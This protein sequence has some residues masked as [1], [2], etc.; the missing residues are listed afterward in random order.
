MKIRTKMISVVLG[1]TI[2]AL[3]IVLF[4]GYKLGKNIVLTNTRDNIL[5]NTRE[6]AAITKVFFNEKFS[7]ANTIGS[8]P[9]LIKTL[10]S[11]NLELSALSE[12]QRDE[13][14]DTLNKK[15]I[16]ASDLKSPFIQ[17]YMN[18]SLANYLRKQQ[19]VI[20]GEYGE[21]FLTNR[22]GVLIATTGKLTTLAHSHKYW[23]RACYNNGSGKG[24]I[25]DRGYDESVGDNVVGIVVPIMSDGH[26]IGVLK[27]N[28]FTKSLSEF[29]NYDHRNKHNNESNLASFLLRSNGE[30]IFKSNDILDTTSEILIRKKINGKAGKPEFIFEEEEYMAAYVPIDVPFA[31]DDRDSSQQVLLIDHKQGNTGQDWWFATHTTTTN[32]LAPLRKEIKIAIALSLLLIITMTGSVLAMCLKITKPIKL[33]MRYSEKIGRGDLGAKV[34]LESNDELGQLATSFNKMAKDLNA[35]TTSINKLNHEISVH[36]QTRENLD[37]LTA[38]LENTSDLVATAALD[39]QL[40]YFNSAGRRLIGWGG[41]DSLEDK[42]ISNVHPKW[43]TEIIEKEGIP[44]A[45]RDGIW[46]GETAVLDPD[47]KDIH[48][49]QVIMSHKS[50][51]GQVDYLSTII[52]DITQRK[53]AENAL[54]DSKRSLAMAQQVAKIGSWDWNI[55]NDKLAWSDETYRQMGLEPNEIEPTYEAFQKFVHPDDLE[56][57]N[58][59]VGV[60]LEEHKLYSTEA[61][62]I[63]KDGTEW[64]MHA[65]GM[66][67]RN[68]DGKVVRLIGTQQDITERKRV[69]DAL[70]NT[71]EEV[72]Y[73]NKQLEASIERANQ[74][75]QEATVANQTKSEFLA[76]MSHEIRTPM[77]SILGFSEMLAQEQLSDEQQDYVNTIWD[78]GKNLLTIIND[79]LDFSKIEAGKLDTEIIECS[80]EK[81]LGNINSMLRPQATEKGLDFKVLHKTELPAQ[82]R[83]DYTRVYQCL[84]NLVGNAIKFTENGHVHIIVS[85]E[86]IEDKP[87][88]RFDI[89]DTGIG[90]PVDKQEAIF[91]SF[92]QADGSTTR[93]FGGT[94]LGLTI[95]KS[96]AEIL[97]GSITVQSEP[98]KG[99]IFS[100][101]IPAGLDVASQ[102]LLGE[103]YMKEYT[104]ESSET[105]EENYVGNILVAEDNPS[106]QKLIEILLKR[107]GLKVTLVDDGQQAVDEVMTQ[108]FDLVFMDMQMPVM[109]GY[110]VTELLR[111]KEMTVPIV[112]LT[113]NAM[114]QD[115]QECLDAGCD[116]YLAKPV[117]RKKLSKMLGKYL[118]SDSFENIQQVEIQLPPAIEQPDDSPIVSELADDPDLREV[119]EVFVQDLPCQLQK[120]GEAVDSADLD[121]LKYL[122]HTIKGAG[123]SSG[124]PVIMAKAAETEQFILTGELDSLKTA[125]DELTQLC[126]RATADEK[127]S[128]ST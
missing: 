125:I 47:G 35:S 1:T 52:R 117:D 54:L 44:G 94:G 24:I 8:N 120:I 12:K 81:L 111:K 105:A 75:A 18:N 50:S 63:R 79:I 113:A 93:K 103:A 127:A 83:T 15:W 100:L 119:A 3:V 78:S 21:I 74:M 88:I 6:H 114:K 13:Y 92:S 124:F 62:M 9:D 128:T 110:E 85:T 82:I 51:N 26:L 65:Q 10:I 58:E 7:I 31:I 34:K 5:I 56:Q 40:T 68:D 39:Q 84:T 80:L 108:S 11:S 69:E 98:S 107:M 64:V 42:K 41:D 101:M 33:L 77:N 87:F 14:I 53:Q 122:I 43:A 17:S 38:I 104:Q 96:L 49:S 57:I 123:G 66:I 72:E 29:V 30:L 90:I 112:A 115:E 19:Q 70:K 48:V 76:N 97:G 99:S 16:A 22:Y 118:S 23:W 60:T 61:R 116:G 73:S 46:E 126:Q 121:Q 37:R 59:A 67:Q 106:N 89:E 95:T 25:D 45:I 91:E 55:L 86:E 71:K 102:P 20:P 2:S 109:N 28:L 27:S 4:V 36:K 32:A